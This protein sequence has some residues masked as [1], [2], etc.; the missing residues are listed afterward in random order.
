MQKITLGKLEKEVL[1]FLWKREKASLKEVWEHFYT[2]RKLAY[3]TVATV[4]TRLVDKGVVLKEGGV[5]FP[6]YSKKDLSAKILKGFLDTFFKS[7]G[8]VAYSSFA[9]GIEKLDKKQREKL[10]KNLEE[11]LE[12]EK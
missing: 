6:K 10:L 1:E 4:L 2:K 7:F 5:Y 3:T 8:E 11:I 12:S 9:E